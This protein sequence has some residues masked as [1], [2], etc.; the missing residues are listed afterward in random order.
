MGIYGWRVAQRESANKCNGH[1]KFHEHNFS[2]RPSA[3]CP[4][5][6]ERDKCNFL[7]KT[8]TFITSRRYLTQV[9][10]KY[11]NSFS[12]WLVC[13]NFDGKSL[14]LDARLAESNQLTLAILGPWSLDYYL[15]SR[16]LIVVLEQSLTTSPRYENESNSTRWL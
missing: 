5:V 15:Q 3:A 10:S 1:H 11:P 4:S 14:P 12:P 13:S 6:Q 16:P 2:R 8:I 7:G 9:R